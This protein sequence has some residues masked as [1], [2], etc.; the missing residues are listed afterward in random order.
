MRVFLW[1]TGLFAAAFLVHLLIW[2]IRV[3]RFQRGGLMAVF[4]GML[5]A[6]LA[7]FAAFRGA[8][9]DGAFEMILLLV[10]YGSLALAY[11]AL[12]S[13]LEG[14][15]PSMSMVRRVYQAGRAGLDGAVF[16]R[17]LTS[18]RF[19]RA[20]LVYLLKDEMVRLDGDRYV[21]T[22]KGESLLSFYVM[23]AKLAG[24]REKAT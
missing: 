12:Y 18:D 10:Y 3:P 13:S 15:S 20:R 6:A 21:I 22:P 9:P 7:L 19:V 17:E 14:D 2:R 4:G 16:A 23:Y 11:V 1:G 24:Q 5:A 8:A